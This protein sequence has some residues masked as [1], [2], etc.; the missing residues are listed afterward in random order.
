MFR[1]TNPINMKT[2]VLK[3]IILLT[4]TI[5]IIMIVF[6]FSS[7]QYLQVF[8]DTAMVIIFSSMYIWI[9]K[10]PAAYT[11]ASRIILIVGLITIISAQFYGQRQIW[12]PPW[13]LLAF[14]LRGRKEGWIWLLIAEF[15]ITMLYLIGGPEVNLSF[16]DLFILLSDLLFIALITNWYE[17]NK[18][19][20]LTRIKK[21][22][23][24]LEERVNT[25]TQEVE[26]ARVEAVSALRTR[27]EFLANMS[28]EIRTPLNA[29]NG[30]I[31][32]LKEDEKDQQKQEYFEIIQHASHS[33]VQTINDILDYSK[34]E[35]KKSFVVNA[36]FDTE[37]IKDTIKLFEAKAREKEIILHAQ[38]SDGI[39]Q[40]LNG[41]IQKIR[42]TLNNLLSNALKFTPK[43]GSVICD[44][45][46]KEERLSISMQDNGVGI[47]KEKLDTIFEPFTQA[48]G[49]TQR[50]YGGSGLGLA[51]CS[52]YVKMMGGQLQVESVYGE[53]SRFYF[54]LPLEVIK[55][56]PEQKDE[57]NASSHLKGHVLLAE[58][59]R[60][61]Q[62]FMGLLFSNI[63]L[64]Y[65][66][67]PDGLAAVEMSGTNTYD[68]ILMDE[69]MPHMSGI[70]ATQK[71][72]KREKEQQ[73]K[74]TPIIALTANALTGDKERFLAAGMDDYISKPVNVEDMIKLLKKYIKDEHV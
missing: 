10:V 9:E 13:I 48:D 2:H 6:R 8:I 64:S 55:K 47:P 30:F 5:V 34:L 36:P 42:Q 39:P 59:N 24:Q 26:E 7:H 32:L 70:K 65:E 18:E 20:I 44:V 1:K 35:S 54:S 72:L 60:A 56:S 67:A 19:T 40:Y 73:L 41:D 71:I 17:I 62:L 14:F 58:D 53:G 66:V 27:S 57:S 23:S 16:Q 31:S 33:L 12:F 15:T 37:E 61:N 51:I 29:I 74:H 28:H 21:T 68:V 49:S 4:I 38:C 25:R 45:S 43:S 63:G 11:T 52:A 69:H 50:E 22:N 46:F 3:Q